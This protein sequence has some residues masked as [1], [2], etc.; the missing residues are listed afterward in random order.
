VNIYMLTQAMDKREKVQLIREADHIRLELRLE[1]FRALSYVGS[2]INRD[3]FISL[4]VIGW[5]DTPTGPSSPLSIPKAKELLEEAEQEVSIQ[6]VTAL[7]RVAAEYYDLI[8]YLQ[9]NRY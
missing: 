1:L 6:A 2:R 4:C 3:L 9:T 7:R 8:V 5:T